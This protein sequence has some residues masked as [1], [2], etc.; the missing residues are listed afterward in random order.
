MEERLDILLVDDYDN[1]LAL[2]GE[3]VERA[4]PRI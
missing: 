2:L 4:Q 1:E 3:A